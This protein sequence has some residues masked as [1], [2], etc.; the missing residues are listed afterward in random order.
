M[1]TTNEYKQKTLIDSAVVVT[2]LAVVLGLTGCQKE[3]TAEQAGKKVDNAAEKAEQKIERTT[4]KVG[5]ELESAKE[6]V[7]DKAAT[8]GEFIDDSVITTTVKAAI[9]NDPLLHAS[10]IEVTTDKGVVKLSGT[11]D[12]EPNISKAIEVAKR[13]KNVLSVESSLVVNIMPG[14]M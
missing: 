5:K 12:S 14:K 8:A 1:K 7:T 9:L 10:H 2:C 4:E 6:S 11:V 13:Q 3:G